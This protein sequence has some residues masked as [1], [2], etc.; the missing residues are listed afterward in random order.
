MTIATTY[1][2]TIALI[3]NQ[4]AEVFMNNTLTTVER[5]RTDSSSTIDTIHQ[6]DKARLAVIFIASLV[7]V[8][9]VGL[10]FIACFCKKGRRFLMT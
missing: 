6:I 5:Y 7:A 1:T 10:G 2:L 8:I 9:I 4:D 3:S